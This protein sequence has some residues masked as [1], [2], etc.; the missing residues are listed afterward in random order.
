MNFEINNTDLIE[1][2]KNLNRV[3][4]NRSTLP[5]LSCVL[6]SSDGERLNLRATDLEVS[7]NFSLTSNITEPFNIAVPISKILSICSSLTNEKLKFT[8][9]NYKIKIETGFGEYKIMGQNPEEFPAETKVDK[10]EK[11]TFNS[12]KI[13]ELINYTINSTSTDDLK[14]SLQGVLFDLNEANATLV[15]TDGHKLSKIEH[16]Q[17]NSILK[18]I[19]IPTKFLKLLQSFL[20]DGSEIDLV[21]GENHVQAFFE[22]V[23]I[24]TRLINDQYPDYEKVIPKDN[25]NKITIKTQDLIGSLKRVSVFSNKK[26]KQAVLNIKNNTIEIKAEDVETAASAKEKISCSQEGE[27]KEIII[28]FNGDYL[29]EILDKTKTEETTLLIK[30]SL[31]ATL[32][33]PEGDEEKNKISLLMPIRLN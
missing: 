4:P 12:K 19:I 5:I 20:I 33:L 15:S 32:I 3:V 11:I 14:P 21:V 29:K 23:K 9:S 16:R 8:I 7:L 17:N 2:L 24:S 28:A 22:T 1:A 30:D 13:T 27:T 25:E 6:F 10:S 18:K 26:T 31:S